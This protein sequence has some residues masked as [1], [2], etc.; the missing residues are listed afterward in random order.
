MI[1]VGPASWL[2]ECPYVAKTFNVAIFS[3]Y[4]YDK[5]QSLHDGNTH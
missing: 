5:C 4:K 1:S 3:H 2:A